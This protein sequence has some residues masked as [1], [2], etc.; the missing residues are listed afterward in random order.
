MRPPRLPLPRGAPRG[1][2][3]TPTPT[4][5]RAFSL[6]W[7]RLPGWQS[8]HWRFLGAAALQPFPRLPPPFTL[9]SRYA[10]LCFLDIFDKG[11]DRR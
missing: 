5:P 3:G 9:P 10:C 1:P 6:R 4:R 7:Q 2:I 11:D 8:G